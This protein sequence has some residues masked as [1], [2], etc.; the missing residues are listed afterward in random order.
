[1]MDYYITKQKRK[2]V[3]FPG[4][5]ST[6]IQRRSIKQTIRDSSAARRHN[7]SFLV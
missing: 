6:E 5:P 1:M 2:S 3:A 7:D 4:L